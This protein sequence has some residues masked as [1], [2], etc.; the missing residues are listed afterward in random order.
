[1]YAPGE[2]KVLPRYTDVQHV[3]G[4]I[5]VMRDGDITSLHGV[6]GQVGS[7]DALSASL[8]KHSKLEAV[9]EAFAEAKRTA[10]KK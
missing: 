1:M 5:D 2:P 10:K 4:M 8:Q 3:A 7:F 9:D 6:A